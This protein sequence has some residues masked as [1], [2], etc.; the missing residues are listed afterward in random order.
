MTSILWMIIHF[1]L[2]VYDVRCTCVKHNLSINHLKSQNNGRANK[3]DWLYL[4]RIY[5][6]IDLINTI[7]SF[8]LLNN[9]QCVSGVRMLVHI[10]CEITICDTNINFHRSYVHL[11]NKQWTRFFSS[12]FCCFRAVSMEFESHV[13]CLNAYLLF[14]SDVAVVAVSVNTIIFV[15]VVTNYRTQSIVTYP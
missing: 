3:I 10:V 5:S 13:I 14:F 6:E 8:C 4:Y 15:I 1:S 12:L 11:N 9:S 7:I 2:C